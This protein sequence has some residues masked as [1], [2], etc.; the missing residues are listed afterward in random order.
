MFEVEL[1]DVRNVDAG[2][3]FH[4]PRIL[5]AHLKDPWVRGVFGPVANAGGGE[6]FGD[7]AG[8]IVQAHHLLWQAHLDPAFPRTDAG[9]RLQARSCY[10]GERR[11]GFSWGT[12]SSWW[13]R[14]G[15]AGACAGAARAQE[16]KEG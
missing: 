12:C 9:R 6:I 14:L 3:G 11:Q 2:G 4:R 7:D 1:E 13:P 5:A 16:E 8:A 10:R 15:G